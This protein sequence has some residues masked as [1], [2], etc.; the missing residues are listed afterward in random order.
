[1]EIVA[2][3]GFERSSILS[4][5]EMVVCALPL[6]TYLSLSTS[7]PLPSPPL[8]SLPSSFLPIQCTHHNEI[9]QKLDML[10]FMVKN[11]DSRLLTV[12]TNLDV[13]KNAQYP[14]P[15]Q[16]APVAPAQHSFSPASF[17]SLQP[18]MSAPLVEH[19]TTPVPL[20]L[21]SDEQFLTQALTSIEQPL[22]TT[23]LSTAGELLSAEEI[24]RLRGGSTSRMNFASKL[25]RQL[26]SVL[27]RRQCNV[28]GRQ[29]KGQLD[30]EK[31]EYIKEVTFR[32]YPLEEDE[33]ERMAWNAC[34]VAIDESNR[35]LNKLKH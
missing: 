18:Q 35:R 24:E 20:S 13:I 17:A 30:P 14:T 21:A 1:M 4:T 8:P 33:T 10:T 9:L 27:E 15:G 29:G 19:T 26:F 22:V 11:V 32:M 31:V 23:P 25:N 2:Q 34:I 12:L 5:C 28:R 6:I 16:P 3:F 7:P